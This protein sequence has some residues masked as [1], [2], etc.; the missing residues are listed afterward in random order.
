MRAILAEHKVE[1]HVRALLASFKERAVQSLRGL[2]NES[3]KGLLRRI[4]G[5]I[6]LEKVTGWCKETQEGEAATTAA[7]ASA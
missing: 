2:D 7:P 4:M 3:L 6:F 5:K 1:E